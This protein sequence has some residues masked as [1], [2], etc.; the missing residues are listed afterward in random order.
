MNKEQFTLETLNLD[1]QIKELS[2]KKE[3]IKLDYIEANRP[4]EIGDKI[5]ATRTN[6]EESFGFVTGFIVGYRNEIEIK[7]VK[8]KKDG[9]PSFYEMYIYDYSKLEKV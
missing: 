7:A 3:R 8:C 4:F 6:G 1:N 2:I 5:K 9:T